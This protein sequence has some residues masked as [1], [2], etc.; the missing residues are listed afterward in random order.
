MIA[1]AKKVKDWPMLEAAVDKKME[2]QTE[3][4][5]WWDEK[6][7]PNK[8]GDRQKGEKRGSALFVSEAEDLTDITQQ[9]VAPPSQGAREVSGHALRRGLRQGHGGENA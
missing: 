3:F 7:T 5:R 9:Q 2:D 8:G 6:V 1:Y 4:V